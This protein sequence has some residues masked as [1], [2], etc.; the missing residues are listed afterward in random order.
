[1]R[2]ASW[3]ISALA[4]VVLTH[5]ILVA[6]WQRFRGPN[7]NGIVSDKLIL[8][9]KPR[10]LWTTSVGSGN[11]SLIVQGDR[12]YTVGSQ[13]G[14]GP[15]LVCLN[16]DTG[17]LIWEQRLDAWSGDSS[18]TLLKDK[19][20]LVCDKK[21]PAL[22]CFQLSDG[23]TIW[24]KEMPAATGE[25]HYGHAGSPTLW[26]DL[27]IVN[28]GLGTALKQDTGEIVWSHTGLSGLATPVMYDEEKGQPAV[29]IFAGEGL[30]AREASTGR[31]LWSIPW[32]T[33]L[34]VNACDPIYHDGKVFISTTYGKHAAMF[35]VSASPPKQIWK[36]RGSSFSSGFLWNDHLFYFGGSEFNCL[37]L[38]GNK[39]WSSPGAGGGSALLAGDKILLLNDRG[40]LWVAAASV[41]E[42]R[43]L[44]ET[45]IHGG[46]T[47]TP[48]SLVKGRLFV[49]NK[50]GAAICL[51]I[52]E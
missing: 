12:L 44:F 22:L 30:Y 40:Y 15:V 26:R 29:M 47:W 50:D 51:Q 6:D 21:P 28:V 13:A 2:I 11:A 38:A 1:M 4:V 24:R 20:Y 31:E 8:L 52:G 23:K 17:K 14:R 18:P 5:G 45:R 7:G 34:A 49:R 16:A 36:E 46:T 33:D 48:P 27:V 25:R 9:A 32:K 43:P 42:F 39:K 35:D 19:G 10:E 41:D 3:I 37:D